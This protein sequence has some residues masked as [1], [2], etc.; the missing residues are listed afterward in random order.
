MRSSRR[1]QRDEWATVSLGRGAVVGEELQIDVGPRWTFRALITLHA[2]L[3]F[4][5]AVLAGAFLDGHYAML[6]LHRENAIGLVV[7]GYVQILVAVAYWRPGGGAVWPLWACV[8]M[9]VAE[10]V[11]F[12]L[13]LGRLIG[14][15]VPLGVAIIVCAVLLAQ[16]AWRDTFGRRR[17]SGGGTR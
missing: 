14:L 16:W 12:F 13:G 7:L 4:L 11:Q 15:H 6:G 10:T 2:F 3:V 8:A 5:Q 9:S 1:R 17:D